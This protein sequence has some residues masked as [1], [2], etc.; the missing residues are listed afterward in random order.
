MFNYIKT[1]AANEDGAA[2]VEYAIALLVAAGIGVGT[3]TVM[4][5]QAGTNASLA[6][7]ALTY[8]VATDTSNADC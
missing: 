5:D 1:F 4:G 2:M 6:C 8:D 7:G 3:F